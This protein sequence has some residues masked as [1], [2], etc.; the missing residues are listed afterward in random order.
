MEQRDQEKWEGH[1]RGFCRS[2]SHGRAR[3]HG[4]RV[5]RLK[6]SSVN[7]LSL[8][9][10]ARRDIDIGVRATRIDINMYSPLARVAHR[11]VLLAS[12][13]SVDTERDRWLEKLNRY[14]MEKELLEKMILEQDAAM[15]VVST[16]LLCMK[17]KQ[18]KWKQNKK[19]CQ[20]RT[21][22]YLHLQ[23]EK[24]LRVP[25]LE[26]I[27]WNSFFNVLGIC[28]PSWEIHCVTLF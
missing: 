3:W 4:A 28:P 23:G 14:W 22:K 26:T 12:E 2:R 15:K 19:S 27:F 7:N 5:S 25:A 24:G 13:D 9:I 21:Q 18:L 16:S 17:K 1:G 6:D 8:S 10:E 11:N 20:K